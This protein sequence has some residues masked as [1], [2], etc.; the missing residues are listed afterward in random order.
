MKGSTALAHIGRTVYVRKFLLVSSFSFLSGLLFSRALIFTDCLPF[1]TAFCAGVKKEYSLSSL[2]GVILGSIV[3]ANGYS[4]IIYIGAAL[5]AVALKWVLTLTLDESY[6]NAMVCAGVGGVFGCIAAL[7]INSF[8]INMLFHCVC[9]L[10]IAVG[11]SYFFCVVFSM[12]MPVYSASKMSIEQLSAVLTCTSVLLCALRPY[13]FYISPA[14]IVAE[15]LIICAGFYGKESAGAICGITFGIAL[16][17]ADVD[18]LYVAALFSLAGLLCGVFSRVSRR[19]CALAFM[20]SALIVS[21]GLYGRTDVYSTMIEAS[22]ASTLFLLIPSRLNIR[23]TEFFAPAPY[24]AKADALRSHMVAR[25]SFASKALFDVSESVD[26]VSSRLTKMNLPTVG[27]MF[28]AVRDDAC[29]GCGLHEHCHETQKDS[30][31]DAL[32]CMMKTLRQKGEINKDDYPEKWNARCMYPDK[33]A[34]AVRREYARGEELYLAEQKIAQIR[35]VVSDQMTGL[36]QM[37]ND[38][39]DEFGSTDRYDVDTAAD[40]A[41][42]LSSLGAPPQDICC[43]IDESG[44]MRVEICLPSSNTVRRMSIMNTVARSTAR[45]FAPPIMTDAGDSMMLTFTER[46]NFTVEIGVC[47]ICCEGERLCGDCYAYFDESSGRTVMMISDGMGSGGAAAVDSSMT[48]GLM[49]KL[50][51]AGFGFECSLKLLNSAMMF[52]S[53]AESLATVDIAAVDLYSGQADFY[54]A[55]APDTIIIKGKKSGRA[56]SSSCPA[57]IIR[58]ISFDKTTAMLDFGD[59]IIMTS[60]G[61]DDDDKWVEQLVF[62]NIDLSA[63]KLSEMI[64]NTAR[65]RRNDGHSDDITVMVGIILPNE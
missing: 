25:L 36:A 5:V 49:S 47:E 4:S 56:A 30:T 9:E 39:S 37:L 22:V 17:I 31:C 44:K 28:R 65:T 32:L 52:K 50:I 20:I 59:V 14:M 41:A 40:I 42:A 7:G 63:Q 23:L 1:G 58:N 24:I 10:L 11:A 53:S 21:L 26:M 38:L 62:D 6:A 35:G 60:D 61:V 3:T 55:G 29:A 8:S 2:A 34:D 51:K 18:R 57:G 27:D 54:K 48:T 45:R 19:F 43:K 46:A 33:V 15:L 13:S 64:A 12:N 16:G